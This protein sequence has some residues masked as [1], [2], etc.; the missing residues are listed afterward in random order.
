[1][2]KGLLFVILLLIPSV[3][4]IANIEGP[5]KDIFNLGD[6]IDIS[7][8]ILE[9]EDTWG[10]FKVDLICA[11]KIPLLARTVSIKANEKNEFSEELLIPYYVTG[12]CKIV[13]SLVVGENTIEQVESDSFEISK[14]LIGNFDIDEKMV[15]LGSK[16]V[17]KGTITKKDGERI[18]GLATLYFKKNGDT[19]LIDSVNI[20][21]GS[22]GYIFDSAAKPAGVY[23]LEVFA[24]DLFG[25]EMLF[26]D[27]PEIN[28]VN[29][30]IVVAKPNK[31]SVLPGNFISIFGEAKTVLQ[32]EVSKA[33]VI[34]V[35]DSVQ[36]KTSVKNG[37]FTQRI[38][39]KDSIKSGEHKVHIIIEDE[40]GNIGEADTSFVVNAI[41]TS[42]GLY[43]GGDAFKPNDKV[44]IIPSLYD[45]AGDLIVESINV[46]LLDNKGKEDGKG[47]VESG[48]EIEIELPQFAVPGNWQIVAR[49]SGLE[50]RKEIMVGEISSIDF[51]IENG[52]LVITNIG[53]IKYK[54]YIDI[55]ISGVKGEFQTQ[56][57]ISLRPGKESRLNLGYEIDIDGVYTIMVG[58]KEFK[59]VKIISQSGLFRYDYLYYLLIILFVGFLVWLFLKRKPKI[60]KKKKFV[61]KEVKEIGD[62]EVKKDSKKEYAEA[63]RDMALKNI[64]ESGKKKKLFKKKDAVIRLGDKELYRKKKED[65]VIK[66]ALW[67][68]TS[69]KKTSK[70][71]RKKFVKQSKKDD[72]DSDG[73][74]NM[75]G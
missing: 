41:P 38:K 73:M 62:I 54:D 46:V 35:L 48:K 2:K 20:K 12:N 11:E 51:S 36:Y 27:I 5:S 3:L 31:E 7:G 49:A 8:Y 32:E 13:M 19:S 30:I 70:A 10:L 22:L 68:N 1:M 23:N 59:D 43:I 69:F 67:K 34:S 63:F 60:R 57:K 18:D 37:E 55:S 75:F 40:Q 56:E 47:S 9:T 21:D 39:L 25:N 61:K 74:F 16:V 44:K 29:E 45:Q 72:D 28:L 50:S 42:I 14:D 52:T 58:D 66:D 4:G 65:E 33:D 71:D 17:V 6:K 15:Q 53:N 24:S 64:G 26:T